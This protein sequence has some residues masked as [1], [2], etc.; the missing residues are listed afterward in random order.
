VKNGWQVSPFIEKMS[1][2]LYIMNVKNHSISFLIKNI[3][4]PNVIVSQR[5]TV[6]LCAIDKFIQD[7]QSKRI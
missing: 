7:V 4:I 3:K 2:A 1:I 6:S 5:S